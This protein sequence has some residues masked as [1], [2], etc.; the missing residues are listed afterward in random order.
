MQQQLTVCVGAVDVEGL[1]AVFTTTGLLS[2][3]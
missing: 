1:G 3:P 2:S